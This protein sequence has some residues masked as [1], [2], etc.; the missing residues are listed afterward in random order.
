MHCLNGLPCFAIR[1]VNVFD[2]RVNAADPDAGWLL[3][4]FGYLLADHFRD[5]LHVF[6]TE[7]SFFLRIE[8][9][10]NGLLLPTEPLEFFR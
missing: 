7:E 1:A 4:V 5:R 8:N 2:S 10:A 6:I 9:D 3:Q